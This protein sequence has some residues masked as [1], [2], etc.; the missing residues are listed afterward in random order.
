M[1]QQVDSASQPVGFIE[2]PQE[3]IR[4]LVQVCDMLYSTSAHSTEYC[5]KL[6]QHSPTT[7][8]YNTVPQHSTVT[9]YCNTVLQQITT[10][11]YHNTV[12]QHSTVTQ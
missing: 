1:C 5:N 9:Q 2:E 7:Q 3:Q 8:S 4:T 11:L 10:A 6:L 12:S